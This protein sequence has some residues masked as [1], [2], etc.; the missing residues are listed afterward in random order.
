MFNLSLTLSAY[1]AMPS[2]AGVDQAVLMITEYAVRNAS[3]L[4]DVVGDEVRALQTTSS[5]SGSD[6]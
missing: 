3:I 4:A 6:E 5:S 2:G 1:L